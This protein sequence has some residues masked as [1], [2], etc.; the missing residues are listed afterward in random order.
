MKSTLLVFFLLCFSSAIAQQPVYQSFEVDSAADPRGGSPFLNTFLQTNLR[1]PVAAEAKGI[2]GRVI[3]NAI[4]EPNGSVSDVKV[5]NSLRPDCDREAIRVFSLFK[6]W[7]PGFKGGR[8]VRQQITATVLFKPNPPFIYN[9]GARINYY[10]VDKNPLADSSDKARYKQIAPLDSN[11]FANGDIVVY[12]AKGANWKEEYRIPFARQVNKS[13]DPS[14]Q[15]TIMTG[16]QTNAKSWDGEVIMRSESGS[17]IYQYVYKNGVPT[18]TG[19]HY[20]SNGLVSEKREE[21]EEGLTATSWYDNGQIREI[22]MNKKTKPTDN[23]IPSSV[24]AFWASTGQ[25]LVKN[26]NGRVSNK[27]YRRSYASLL[28]K[29]TVVEEGVYENGL[30]QGI[31]TGRYEDKSFYYEE[32]F[33]KGVF[34]K[35]KSCLLGGDTVT[36]TVLEKTPEFKGGMQA[37]GSFLAQN[38]RYPPDAQRSKIEGQVFLSFIINTDGQVVDIDLIKG[39][40]FGTDEEAIRV[41]KA[42]SGRWVPGHQRGQKINV[43]YN[44]PINFTLQ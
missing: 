34:Q 28:P 11:G 5:M 15:P 30:Q 12:K 43:K 26:G 3:V 42:S 39:L 23:P 13:Q 10:D 19:V 40:G 14:E 29:T 33:D 6:A 24:I 21:F 38:L 18:S 9:N 1:K 17:M 20:S 7:K 16:Y 22:R 36:Y 27:E 37:L 25:Q 8:A 31:W 35:G 4:V 44:V 2:G 32:Q 41:L